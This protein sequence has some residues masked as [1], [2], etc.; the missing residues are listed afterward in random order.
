MP[1]LSR[2][3]L[4]PRRPSALRLLQNPQHLHAAVLSGLSTAQVTERVLWRL[5]S[6]TPHRVEMYMVTDSKPSWEHLVEQAGWPQSDEPQQ[7]VRPYDP[8][9]Q[10]ITEGDEYAFRIRVNPVYAT[11]RPAKPSNAF[12]QRL[13][14][15]TGTDSPPA[16]VRGQRVAHRTAAQQTDWFLKRM[17]QCGFIIPD[18]EHEVP[19]MRLAERGRLTFRKSRT[20]EHRVVLDTATFEGRARIADADSV[21]RALLDGIGSGKAYGCGLLTLAAAHDRS[22]H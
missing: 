9:L 8:L 15:A 4:N 1:Y 12:R 14:N 7:L 11:K 3:Y 21:R 2:V 13:E 17:Q 10:R 6:P 5:E 18:N 20:S 16:R 22:E 19:D